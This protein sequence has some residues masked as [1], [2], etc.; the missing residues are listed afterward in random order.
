MEFKSMFMETNNK[1]LSVVSGENR[2]YM[3]TLA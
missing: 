2:S 3:R 1:V